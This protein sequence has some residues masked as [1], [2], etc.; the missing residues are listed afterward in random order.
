MTEEVKNE[1]IEETKEDKPKPPVKKTTS[2]SKKTTTK[3]STA[4]N[5]KSPSKKSTNLTSQYVSNK[6]LYET[7]TCTIPK[8]VITGNINILEDLKDVMKVETVIPGLGHVEG[9]IKK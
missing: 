2:T 7:V 9:Y 4:S 5:K 6:Y 8:T 3:K 1:S